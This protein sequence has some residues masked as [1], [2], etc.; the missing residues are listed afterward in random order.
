M[1]VII[2]EWIDIA[3]E[4]GMLKFLALSFALAR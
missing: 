1:K 3:P 4:L 2:R